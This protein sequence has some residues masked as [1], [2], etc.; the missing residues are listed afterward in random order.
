MNYCKAIH[1]TDSTSAYRVNKRNDWLDRLVKNYLGISEAYKKKREYDSAYN[2]LYD[3]YWLKD[4]IAGIDV[5]LKIADLEA[6][7]KSLQKDFDLKNEQHALDQAR[8]YLRD[9]VWAAVIGV[10]LLIASLG[11]WFTQNRQAKLENIKDKRSLADLTRL[12]LNKNT[13]LIQLEEQL[14]QNNEKKSVHE[15]GDFEINL[16]NQRI[17][18][19]E[20]WASFKIYFENAYPGYIKRLRMSHPDLTEAE[21]RLFLFIKLNLTNKEAAAILGISAE[22]IKKTRTRLRKRLNLSEEMNLDEYV[23]KF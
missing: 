11:I 5:K 20:D 16:Y 17:L 21:E 12:L 10:I 1:N 6:K 15:S 22:T 23:K 14:S 4:S 19:V 8:N 3:F 18:T 7:N 13:Q 2:Y 9:W